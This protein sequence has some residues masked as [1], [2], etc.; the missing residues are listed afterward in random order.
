[1]QYIM[2]NRLPQL[3]HIRR[4]IL[5]YNIGTFLLMPLLAVFSENAT[6]GLQTGPVLDQQRCLTKYR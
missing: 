3:S 1:M 2:G 5:H 4:K 6:I